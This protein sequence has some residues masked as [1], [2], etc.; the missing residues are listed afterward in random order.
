MKLRKLRSMPA[1]SGLIHASAPGESMY[2]LSR[3]LAGRV[4]P[5]T[6]IT[7]RPRPTAVFMFLDTARYEHIP[8]KYA[9]TMLSTKIDFTNKLINSCIAVMC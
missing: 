7:A 5:S 4:T 8:R 1:Y 6:N 2:L 3:K 9:N